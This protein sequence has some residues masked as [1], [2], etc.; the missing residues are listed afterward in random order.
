M[1]RVHLSPPQLATDDIERVNA[2]LHS[3]WIAPVG[4]ELD[5]FE[6]EFATL[7]GVRHALAL[8]SG[9]SALHL[10]LLA[11]GVGAGDEVLVSTLTVAASVNPIRY[12]GA[13]PILVDSSTATWTM[14]PLLADRTIT[15]LAA[16]GRAPKALV[17]VHLY[18]Q[19]ADIEPIQRVC[20]AHGVA[21]IED[22]A[23]AL[24]SSYRGRPAGSFGHAA[25]FSF[26]G[27]KIITTSG[28]GMLVSNDAPF[29]SRARK[30][31]NQAREPV[32]HYQHAE[33]GYNYRLSNVLAALGRSQLGELDARVAARRHVF[34]WYVARLGDAPGLA[35]MPEAEYGRCNRWLSVLTVD[36]A[37]AGFSRDLAIERLEAADIE[38]RPVWKPMHQQP[39]FA[40]CEVAGGAVSERLFAQ[41]LCLP[42]GSGLS[43]A[44]VERVCD[45]ILACGP[46]R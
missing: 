25:I 35:F 37:R 18:G 40:A 10:A 20:D 23:E 46:R 39:V 44:E 28:G 19:C 24:G 21:I 5:G 7:I 13:R 36:P 6:A 12:V 34:E 17:L 2:A 9:T 33:V 3:G 43:R 45:I 30:L 22:A 1:P 15:G 26:N 14:D 8:N 32:R 29:M 16:Q 42:S 38:S 4:P 41:G 31:A 11:A 27:N